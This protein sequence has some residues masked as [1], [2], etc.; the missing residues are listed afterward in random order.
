MAVTHDS[1]I[2]IDLTGPALAATPRGLDKLLLLSEDSGILP[3][4]T[5]EFTT[6]AAAQADTDLSAAEKAAIQ[7]AF[8]QQ[9]QPTSVI[10]GAVDFTSGSESHADA[11]N[12][13][14]ADGIDFY[15]VTCLTRDDTDIVGVDG[16]VAAAAQPYIQYAQSDDATNLLDGAISGGGLSSISGSGRTCLVYHDEDTEYGAEAALAGVLAFDIDSTTA[17]A[18]RRVRGVDAYT[19]K[20]TASQKTQAEGN[21]VNLILPYGPVNTYF[22][23]GKMLDG[24]PVLDTLSGDWFKV[25]LEEDLINLK[26]RYDA[27][28]DIIPVSRA[29][30]N[31]LASVIQ[32]RLDDGVDI[33]KFVEE[34][35]EESADGLR[36]PRIELPAITSTDTSLQRLR[37]TVYIKI[38]RSARIFAIPVNLS[39]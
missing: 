12:A 27:A 11:L 31:I 33:G 29:G 25:R 23:P 16:V 2:D 5:R 38:A 1:N 7:T 18:E 36:Y 10:I 37:A 9:P 30:Q 15:G 17:S 13:V 35:P 14:I 22:D 21:N 4:R 34:T 26:L 24:N 8:S 19:S 20:I 32:A 39:V 28:G 6:N 3:D